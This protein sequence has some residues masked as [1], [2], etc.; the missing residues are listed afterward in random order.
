MSCFHLSNGASGNKNGSW[1]FGPYWVDGRASLVWS[2]F[3]KGFCMGALGRTANF[4]V[5][6]SGSIATMMYGFCKASNQGI[7]NMLC[8][9][10]K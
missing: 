1:V 3:A 2:E 9:L 10:V 8:E 4:Q 7:F 5:V 6:A